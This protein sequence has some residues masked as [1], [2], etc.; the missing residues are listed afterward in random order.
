MYIGLWAIHMWAFERVLD[1]DLNVVWV[2]GE[3]FGLIKLL[4]KNM[5]GQ[6]CNLWAGPPQPTSQV[7][8]ACATRLLKGS[9]ILN[10][11]SV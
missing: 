10:P 1:L 8:R 3:C 2:G 7:G 5:V 6:P 11:N 9:K 4:K